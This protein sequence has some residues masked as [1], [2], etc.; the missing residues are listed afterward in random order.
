MSTYAQP[1]NETKGQTMTDTSETVAYGYI[2]TKGR[3]RN[4]TT[5]RQDARSAALRNVGPTASIVVLRTNERGGV[6][7]GVGAPSPVIRWESL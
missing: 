6:D 1:P 5:D 3:I 2:D 7:A 4:I